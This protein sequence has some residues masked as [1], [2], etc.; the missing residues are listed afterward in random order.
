MSEDRLLQ[1]RFA[2]RL[3]D[4][5]GQ[6]MYGVLFLLLQNWSQTHGMRMRTK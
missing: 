2:G 1:I 5:L 4:L 3:I 6:Q